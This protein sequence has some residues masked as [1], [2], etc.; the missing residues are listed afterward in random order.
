MCCLVQLVS[1]HPLLLAE[2]R[3]QTGL[4]LPAQSSSISMRRG[5]RTLWRV[6]ILATG[7]SHT[8]APACIPGRLQQT[9]INDS[10]TV[11]VCP[12]AF[13]DAGPS[14]ELS[15]S[16]N[17]ALR[18]VPMGAIQS[19]AMCHLSTNGDYTC[20]QSSDSS[21]TRASAGGFQVTPVGRMWQGK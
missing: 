11:Q 12:R 21:G 6:L 17:A 7:S 3:Q 13:G 9:Y 2:K 16:H 18:I 20:M 5:E 1:V 10:H 4:A 14:A 8:V 15:Q 19:V